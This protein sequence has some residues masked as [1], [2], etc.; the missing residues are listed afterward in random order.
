[1]LRHRVVGV[2]SDRILRVEVNAEGKR[3]AVVSCNIPRQLLS[4]LLQSFSLSDHQ[5][6]SP[7]I[8]FTPFAYDIPYY[9][10]NNVRTCTDSVVQPDP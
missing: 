8:M 7:L 5:L 6:L 10:I 3:V 4:D 9:N 2:G 1:M